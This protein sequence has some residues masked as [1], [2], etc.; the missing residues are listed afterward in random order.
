MLYYL[1]LPIH[2]L[3]SH[4]LRKKQLLRLRLFTDIFSFKVVACL[5]TFW[6]GFLVIFIS[7]MFLLLFSDL[8]IY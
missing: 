1:F 2:N 3:K 7:I 8:L 4:V 6:Y 5:V